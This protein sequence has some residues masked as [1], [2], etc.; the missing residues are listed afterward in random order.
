[1]PNNARAV[2]SGQFVEMQM[3][4][5]FRMTFNNRFTRVFGAGFNGH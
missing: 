1:M 3:L 2:T 4:M 5:R